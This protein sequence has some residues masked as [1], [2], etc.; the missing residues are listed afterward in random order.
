V[1]DRALL[2]VLVFSGCYRD[3]AKPIENAAGGARRVGAAALR[4][5]R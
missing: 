4:R 2:V 3:T 5:P 1:I